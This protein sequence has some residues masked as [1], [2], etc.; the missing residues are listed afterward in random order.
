MKIIIKH[1]YALHLKKKHVFYPHFYGP[2][3][4]FYNKK[5]IRDN[6]YYQHLKKQ[7][8]L[9]NKERIFVTIHFYLFYYFLGGRIVHYGS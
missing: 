4:L 5:N 2:G 1:L 6:A 7:F 3:H 9:K 8:F